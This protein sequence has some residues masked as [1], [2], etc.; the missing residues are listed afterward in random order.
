M[1]S[2]TTLQTR[3]LQRVAD[4]RS[5]CPGW[6]QQPLCVLAVQKLSPFP[7]LAVTVIASAAQLFSCC[8][9]MGFWKLVFVHTGESTWPDWYVSQLVIAHAS[10][11]LCAEMSFCHPTCSPYWLTVLVLLPSCYEGRWDP[12]SLFLCHCLITYRIVGV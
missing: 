11:M 4:L 9:V 3:F 8:T 1:M 7:F 10:G 12:K 2:M 5:Y 6:L